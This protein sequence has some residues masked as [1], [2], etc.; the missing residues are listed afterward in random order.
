M[1]VKKYQEKVK[2]H[3]GGTQQCMHILTFIGLDFCAIV[4]IKGYFMPNFYCNRVS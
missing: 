3:C 1:N 4:I 2:M